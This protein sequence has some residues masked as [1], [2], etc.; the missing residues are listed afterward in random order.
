MTEK[1]TSSPEALAS[2][3]RKLQLS[4]TTAN[5]VE[6]LFSYPAAT[7][8]LRSIQT[9]LNTSE[10]LI[11][12]GYGYR[13]T[14]PTHEGLAPVLTALPDS[15]ALMSP[16]DVLKWYLESKRN[17]LKALRQYRLSLQ[18]LANACEQKSA[19]YS[20][21]A[22]PEF[23][24][25][26]FGECDALS[27]LRGAIDGAKTSI[28]RAAAKAEADAAAL[29]RL[30][31]EYLSSEAQS[32]ESSL[33]SLDRL[34]WVRASGRLPTENDRLSEHIDARAVALF[35]EG[36]ASAEEMRVEAVACLS[37]VTSWYQALRQYRQQM[38]HGTAADGVHKSLKSRVADELTSRSNRLKNE[39]CPFAAAL[40]FDAVWARTRVHDLELRK[41]H[42][43]FRMSASRKVNNVLASQ[44]LRLTIVTEIFR[45]RAGI[46]RQAITDIQ[47]KLSLCEHER[48]PS[49]TMNKFEIKLARMNDDSSKFDKTTQGRVGNLNA[50]SRS[51]RLS[52]C[53]TRLE[54]KKSL[55]Y[56][57]DSIVGTLSSILLKFR[58]HVGT[59]TR[60]IA[61]DKSIC[62]A[63]GLRD[64]QSSVGTAGKSLDHLLKLYSAYENSRK[65]ERVLAV[66]IA[67]FAPSSPLERLAE[68]Q[69][70][71]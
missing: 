51:S 40:A 59:D 22:L 49:C 44:R 67:F 7:S 68:L 26:T 46:L 54:I 43:S 33:V 6:W 41:V 13:Y 1:I 18:K 60:W 14:H 34:E 38:N 47:S 3:L 63:T 53:S 27:D 28:G 55:L 70:V 69:S 29:D 48:H 58:K 66:W 17:R 32:C 25:P 71:S 11:P 52:S 8:L 50:I 65:A 9:T 39:V 19:V 2:V 10:C 24:R 61:L 15:Q 64:L 4:S 62:I 12:E 57:D 30:L 36:C 20:E 42:Q 21:Y 37:K 45:I 16:L 56:F 5:D 23:D 31:P 35:A